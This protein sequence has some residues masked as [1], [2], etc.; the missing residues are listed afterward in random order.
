[1]KLQSHRTLFLIP[2][3]TAA[4]SLCGFSQTV[5]NPSFEMPGFPEANPFII[6][7]SGSGFITGWTVGGAGLDYFKSPPAGAPASDGFYF[8]DLV[9]GPGQGGSISTTAT[10]LT[11]GN[12]YNLTF[13]IQQGAIEPGTVITAMAG[14]SSAPF[15]NT[16]SN[17][18]AAHSLMFLAT[19]STVPIS[20]S[21]PSIGG[22]DVGVFLDNVRIEGVL[23]VPEPGGI[24][25]GI[26]A[27]GYLVITHCVRRRQV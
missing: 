17:V 8:V 11:L 23:S 3:F 9:R 6:L 20:F 5:P 18:W 26:L 27:I 22:D 24:A 2:L 10:G 7:P 1:M 15:L 12:F 25:A 13:D 19:A 14:L 16:T 4:F 21:G